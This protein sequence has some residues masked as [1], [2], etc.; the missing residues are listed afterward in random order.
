MSKILLV[1]C[2]FLMLT[3]TPSVKA[4]PLV[5]TSGSL[6]P[7]IGIFDGPEYNLSG[8]NFS[9]GG[10]GTRILRPSEVFPM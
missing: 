4:D 1:L 6:G 5:V 9:I 3:L 10:G 7:L 8:E 2:A